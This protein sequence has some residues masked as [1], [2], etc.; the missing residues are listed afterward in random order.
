MKSHPVPSISISESPRCLFR[1]Q[2]GQCRMLAVD[3][4]ATLCLYHARQAMPQVPDTVD[5][6][7]SLTKPPT[8]FHDAQSITDALAV[9]FSLLAQGRI[10]PRRATALAY[11]ANLLLHNLPAAE[12]KCSGQSSDWSAATNNDDSAD[13]SPAPLPKRSG[14]SSDWPATNNNNDLVDQSPIPASPRP[15]T[16]SPAT[17]VS[18]S[19]MP[20]PK[21]QPLPHTVEGFL[22][23]VQ[24]QID[25]TRDQRNTS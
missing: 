11:I 15:N 16:N 14:Q 8:R 3:F 12:P 25:T 4:S 22:A 6:L 5:L 9:L 18:R 20:T 10:S 1:T 19:S 17:N 23:A 13:Q 2:N 21:S 7:Q 24:N